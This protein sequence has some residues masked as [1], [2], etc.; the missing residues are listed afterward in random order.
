MVHI[1]KKIF[2]KKKYMGK[3]PWKRVDIGIC[4]YE[5]LCGTPVEKEMATHSSILA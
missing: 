2:K 4:I 1:L 5:S 3:D